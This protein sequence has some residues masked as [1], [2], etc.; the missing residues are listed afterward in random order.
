MNRVD[1]GPLRAGKEKG[2]PR[3]ISS[4]WQPQ[5]KPAATARTPHTT[6]RSLPHTLV[7]P[8]TLPKST[9]DERRKQNRLEAE[10]APIRMVVGRLDTSFA[11]VRGLEVVVRLRFGLVV[12][13]CEGDG[14]PRPHPSM[15][16]STSK[17]SRKKKKKKKANTRKP[18]PI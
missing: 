13:Q 12:G 14:P 6:S 9:D 5:P 18:D 1:R 2:L 11:V 15:S 4:H 17:K 3:S 8:H 10:E 16:K 7:G